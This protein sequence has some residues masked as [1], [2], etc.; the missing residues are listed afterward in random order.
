[1]N[2]FYLERIESDEF[3]YDEM[4]SCVVIADDERHA[5]E[6]AKHHAGDEG[7][8]VMARALLGALHTTSGSPGYD[9]VQML[10]AL[11]RENWVLVKLPTPTDVVVLDDGRRRADFGLVVATTQLDGGTTIE[12][13]GAPTDGP[14][15]GPIAMLAATRWAMTLARQASND[16][17]AGGGDQP[18]SNPDGWCCTNWP[19][20][21][22]YHPGHV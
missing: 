6:Y 5:R 15:S 3:G 21:G 16:N 19:H 18:M 1:M 10:A 7:G 8:Y 17:A 22:H 4:Y 2:V 12:S 13:K 9:A 14:D 20:C 11:E